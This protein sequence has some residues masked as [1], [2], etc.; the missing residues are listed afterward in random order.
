MGLDGRGQP[1][2][3]EQTD[4]QTDIITGLCHTTSSCDK[5]TSQTV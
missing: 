1:D 2:S 5:N 3:D 4:R